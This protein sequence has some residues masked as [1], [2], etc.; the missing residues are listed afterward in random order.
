MIAPPA[1]AARRRLT[2][3]LAAVS[4]VLAGCTAPPGA[5]GVAPAPRPPAADDTAPAAPS[6]QSAAV[7]A[8]FA[9][10]QAE[11]LARG[12][13]RT[14]A[15]GPDTPFGPRQLAENFVRIALYDEYAAVGGGRL[16]ARPTPAALRR[17][18]GPVRIG[19]R[20]GASVPAGQRQR[21]RAAVAAYAQR[22]QRAT[23]HSVALSDM[24]PNYWLYI[25][26]EDERPG[27]G[28]EWSRLFPGIS[29]ADLSPVTGMTLSTF[30]IVLA[31]SEG[32]SP[33]YTGALAVVR[34]ELPDLLRL[35]CIHEELAQGL[36]LANDHP[37]ARPSIFNDDEEFALLT[38]HDE[39]LLRMLYDPRLRPGMR[40]PEARPVVEAIAAG[41]LGGGS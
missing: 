2:A 33:V 14:D 25:V 1:T 39:L 8:H 34:A 28:P 26:S 40:E 20:F 24:R 5:V 32:D 22:L 30:C 21:D 18:E 19:L 31:I 12:L 17:W 11:A 9:R 6:A 15:G 4:L 37:A 3:A 35:S 27:L 23:G 29:V 16:V 13:M 7:R 41:L 10:V 36:G 38:R